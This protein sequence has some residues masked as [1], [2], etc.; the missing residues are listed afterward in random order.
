MIDPRAEYDRRLAAWRERIAALDRINFIISNIRLAIA[1]AGAVLLWLAF[2]RA[3]ISPAW[4]LAAWLSFGGLAILHAKRLQR[5]ERA[6]AAERV[7][8]RGLERLS[9]RWTGGGPGGARDGARFL[10][11]HAYAGDLDLFGPGSIHV[12]HTADEFVS[13]AE[14]TAAAGHYVT[15]AKAL[16][17]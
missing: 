4:P 11:G 3:S 5:F 17:G 2:V 1:L 7:Y 14:L 6:Q 13:I 12:A 16:L 9:G 8:L 15:L 10:D